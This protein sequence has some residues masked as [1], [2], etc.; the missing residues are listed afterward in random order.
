MCILSLFSA[1]SCMRD[2]IKR[3]TVQSD[4]SHSS[5]IFHTSRDGLYYNTCLRVKCRRSS[6]ASHRGSGGYAHAQESYISVYIPYALPSPNWHTLLIVHKVPPHFRLTHTWQHLPFLQNHNP[7]CFCYFIT[8]RHTPLPPTP[9]A[10]KN[11]QQ[12]TQ[13]PSCQESVTIHTTPWPSG[14]GDNSHNPLAIRNQWQSPPPPPPPGL[15]GISDNSH[16]P[17]AIKNEQQFAWPHSCQESVTIHTT[18]WPS[19]ISDNSHNPLAIKNQ[20]Q[21]TQPHWP[22]GISDNSH[23]PPDVRNQWQFTQPPRCQE[24][25]TIP[26]PPPPPRISHNSHNPLAVKNQWR[27]TQSLVISGQA[28]AR[29]RIAE[30]MTGVTI[31]VL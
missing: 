5:F 9:L 28:P 12:I 8:K 27:L 10:I 29:F 22:S 1:L 4:F 21:F 15:S 31:L 14:I 7:F 19:R 13:P 3:Q 17:L 6:V 24:S 25:V 30:I 2:T 18:P 20:W 23:N 11:Q 26:P 16:N